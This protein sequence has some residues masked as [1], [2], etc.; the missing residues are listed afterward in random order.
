M[1]G[2]AIIIVLDSLGIGSAADAARFNDEGSN[3]LGHISQAYKLNLPNLTKLGLRE[4][5]HSASGSIYGMDPQP[6]SEPACWAIGEE[7]GSGKDTV[8][9][10]WEIAGCIPT[11]D[12]GYFTNLQNSFPKELTDNILQKAN[13]DDYL[14]NCHASGTEIIARLGREHIK[15]GFPIFYTSAD[16]VFQIAAHEEHFGLDRLYKLCE[17]AYEA[18]K[19]YN[20]CRI[21]AR[22][23]VGEDPSNFKRTHNRRDYAVPPFTE[24]LLSVAQANGVHVV[25]IGKIADIYAHI[26][27]DDKLKTPWNEGNVTDIIHA[28]STYEDNTLIFANLADFDVL[29]GHRRDPIGYGKALEAFDARLPE[30]IE[31]LKEDDLLIITADHGNDPTWKGTDHT[32][33]YIPVLVHKAGMQPGYIGKRKFADIGQTLC[34]HLGVP[35]QPAGTSFY[36]EITDKSKRS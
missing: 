6:N 15:T 27:I 17:I 26:G 35:S 3:T 12:W 7:G 28:L 13:I 23:F 19:P 22:P 4:A 32:R 33:E 29:Y 30:I 31:L 36:K 16:S 11:Q 18:V 20:I 24:T 1:K 2:R 25:S 34:E 21:I 14:G 10:H 9:G 8:S 5:L